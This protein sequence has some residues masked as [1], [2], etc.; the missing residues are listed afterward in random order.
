MNFPLHD[1][2]TAPEEARGALAATK[3]NFGM[4]PNLEKVMASAPPLL[5]GYAALWDIFNTTTL[6][7]IE[8]QVVYLTANFEN[9]CNYCVPWHS[10]LAKQVGM[11]KIEIEAL[12]CGEKMSDRK[13]EVL[14]TFSRTLI[15]K[16]GKTT[17]QDLQDFLDVGYSEVQALEVILGLAVKLM[18]NF[19]NSIADTPLDPKVE[20]LRWKKPEVSEYLECR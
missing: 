2:T 19:T 17:K 7:P 8:R 16:R 20:S 13:L 4:I 14:R 12:R 9:E 15:E 6:S 1:E 3:K 18:S 5:T 10:L 11:K